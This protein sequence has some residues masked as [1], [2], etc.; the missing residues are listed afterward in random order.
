MFTKLTEKQLQSKTDFIDRYMTA[1]NAAD[2]SLFDANANVSCKNIATLETELNKDINIQVNRAIMGKYL[3][4]EYDEDTAVKFFNLLNNHYVYVHDETSLKPYCASISMYP[5]L[6]NGMRDLGGESKVPQ[7][8]ES[9]CGSFVNLV[10]AVAAQFAG[11]VATVEFLMYFDKFA[12]QDYGDDYLS[13][14]RERI[15]N[16]LQHI[17][18]SLNQPA[19][20]RGYQCVFWNISLYDKE[21]FESM[22][23]DFKFPDGETPS[24]DSV[25]KLQAFFLSWINDERTRSILTYP[26][27]TAAMLIENDK[28]KDKEFAEMCAEELAHGNTFFIYMSENA[29][30]LS[31]CCRLRSGIVDREFSY[32]LGAGGVSTGSIKVVTLNISRIIQDGKNI[33]DIVDIVHK[34]L[35]CFRKFVE[36]Q[37]NHRMLPV[38]DAGYI[39]LN[40]QY[41]TIGIN[42]IV[43]AAESSGIDISYNEEYKEFVDNILKMVYDKNREQASLTGYKFNTE[44]V[45][46]ENLGTKNSKWD[47]QD[48]ELIELTL[49]NGETIVYNAHDMVKLKSGKYVK[50]CLLTDKDEIDV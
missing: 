20:A 7:H 15:V 31:S 45:P 23:G 12:R 21:Y 17:V 26:I 13:T 1:N 19:S 33:S 34:Y 4:N 49:D 18:Y 46:A 32:T 25:K 50:A 10:F 44:M 37:Q 36:Y 35:V 3:T 28:P 2:G 41:L 27:I 47:K 8:I 22:F 38:Y 14:H 11:A 9:F 29:D 48:H 30:S 6:L 24:W 42:G 39:S 43:E 16:H 5:F 40:K